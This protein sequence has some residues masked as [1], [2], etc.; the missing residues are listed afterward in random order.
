MYLECTPELPLYRPNYP[1]YNQKYHTSARK[2]DVL[3]IQRQQEAVCF[4][5][6]ISNQKQYYLVLLCK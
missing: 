3:C 6:F 2:N 4:L 5:L 1:E